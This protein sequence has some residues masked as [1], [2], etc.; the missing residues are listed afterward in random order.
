MFVKLGV[1]L[2]VVNDPASTLSGNLV[3]QLSVTVAFCRNTSGAKLLNRKFL[4]VVIK[5]LA[6][7]GLRSSMLLG[8]EAMPSWQRSAPPAQTHSTLAEGTCTKGT[9]LF[10]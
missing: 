10:C 1:L 7:F 9:Q 3:L 5:Q 4:A 2:P 8:G 6:Y